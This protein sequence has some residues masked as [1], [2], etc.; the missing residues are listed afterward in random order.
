MFRRN[1]SA[2]LEMVFGAPPTL[3][4][5]VANMY[6]Y[7]TNLRSR[8]VKAHAHVRRNMRSAVDRHRQAYYRTGAPIGPHSL[9]GCGRPGLGRASPGSLHCTE[10][11]SLVV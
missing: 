10:A 3:P 8:M 11:G 4:D 5:D 1:A 2:S 7:T 6:K 9:C